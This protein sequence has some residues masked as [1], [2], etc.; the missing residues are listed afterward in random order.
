VIFKTSNGGGI[1]TNIINPV[2]TIPEKYNL[3]QNYPNPFNPVTNIEITVPS[4]SFVKLV[5]YDI[6]GREIERLVNADL[7]AGV[8]KI[9]WNAVS[10]PSGVYFYKIVTDEFTETK[11]MILVK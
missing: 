5:I 8:Y 4:A 11:K 3:F 9:D 7:K 1:L 10:Y 2:N 6:M